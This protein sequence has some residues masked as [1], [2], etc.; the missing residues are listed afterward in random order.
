MFMWGSYLM[1]IQNEWLYKGQYITSRDEMPQGTIGFIY[2]LTHISSGKKYIGRK[3]VDKAH[4]RQKNKKIIR[5]RI[6]SD[7]REY[8]SSSPDV[9]DLVESEGHAN[10]T[11][12]I[13]GFAENKSQLNYLEECL[14][15]TFGVLESDN[16]L[17]SNIRSKSYKRFILDKESIKNMRVFIN[18]HIGSTGP[19]SLYIVVS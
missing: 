15:Y 12:E 17:N 6:E 19:E 11:R 14:Q 18:E 1:D 10:F 2:L 13:I 7:W 16:W 3:L 8:W 4:R 9:K 5:T